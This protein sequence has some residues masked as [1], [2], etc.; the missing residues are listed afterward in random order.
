M[1]NPIYIIAIALGAGFIL[2]LLDRLDRK[3]S[4]VIF[5]GALFAIAAIPSMWLIR[6][7]NGG[8]GIV[9]HTA[10]FEPPFSIH[11]RLF[12]R[13]VWALTLVNIGALLGAFYMFK[14]L[15]ADTARSMV[16]YLALILGINGIVMTR[17]LFNLFVFLEITS[18]AT[19]GLIAIERNIRSLSAGFKYILAGGLAS[20]LYL[21]GT[22]YI[23]RLTGTLSI[24]HIIGSGG[25]V[26]FQSGFVA[27]FLVLSAILIELKP[28]PANGWGIDVYQ[29]AQ[30]GVAAII[31]FGTSTAM[32]FALHKLLPLAQ[33]SVYVVIILAGLIS[34]FLSNLI[35]MKQVDV[36]R[37]LGYSS[38]A[39]IG[40]IFAAMAMMSYLGENGPIYLYIVGGL[41]LNH[42]LAKGG[43]FWIVGIIGKRNMQDWKSAE[44]KPLYKFMM[45]AFVFALVGLPP[46]PGFWAKWYLITKLAT[47]NYYVWIAL[48]L[49]GSLFEAVYLFRWL[50]IAKTDE[51]EDATPW[52][53]AGRVIPIWIFFG[54]IT[55]AGLIFPIKLDWIS[56][57]MVYPLIAGGAIYVLRDYSQKLRAFLLLL[58]VA[59]FTLYVW[60]ELSGLTMVFGGMFL[61]A[62]GLIAISAFVEKRRSG[63]F[64]AL[65][66]TLIL[67]FG[68]LLIAETLLEFLFAWEIMTLASYILITMGKRSRMASLR[69]IIFSLAGSFLLLF[70]FAVAARG[71]PF[72]PISNL[73]YSSRDIG[74]AFVAIFIGFLIKIGAVGLHIWL[75]G[76][77][78]ESPDE[79]STLLSA[80]MSK[81]GIFALMVF[82]ALTGG[83]VAG[84]DIYYIIGWIGLLTAFFGTLLAVFQEDVKYLLAYSSLGQVGYIVLAFALMNHAGWTTALYLSVNHLLF[85]GMLFL[86][87]AGVIYRLKTSKMYEMGG[88]IQ[89]MPLSFISVLIGII[90][91]SGVPPLTGFGGKWLLYSSLI[92]KGWYVQAGIAFFASTIAF[93]YCFRLIHTVFLGQLK[94]ENRDVKEAPI[95][96]LIPQF[97]FIMAIMA[98]SMFPQ[99][100]VKPVAAA[101]SDYF[102]PAL[103]WE[104]GAL[105]NSIGYWNGA[106]V[107]NVTM[108]VF[109]IPLIWL[110]VTKRKSKRVGQFNIVFAAERPDR[111]ETTHF[112]H[113]FFAPYR[114]A[115]G[116]FV[117]PGIE[118]FWNGISEGTHSVASAIRIIYTGNGQTYALY[119]IL[120][121][122][123]LFAFAGGFR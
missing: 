91:L 115:L 81:V 6:M 48:I 69:Y 100:L 40:L 71:Y 59:A 26:A 86:A 83:Y 23:Y 56:Q 76:A 38:V 47:G 29:G 52:E 77:Y 84:L 7:I 36:R 55:A 62:G 17:D 94:T 103:Y 114:K 101:A 99:L 44:I 80:V 75:P 27:V 96:F 49:F 50:G 30:T 43:L 82:A 66:A 110:F 97:V 22:I 63:G 113:N 111:P 37:M 79:V 92:E 14:E 51:R 109:A 34:F 107:M 35:G 9:I 74:F 93:L 3:I 64:Y 85:K 33:Q 87:A 18:I 89:K 24:D 98:F 11:L 108:V 73:F 105:W 20:A 120:Y 104:N 106:L 54:A 10:G 68:T 60:P 41:L 90:A 121:V 122:I 13:E 4:F 25:L 78:S 116:F 117:R 88:L 1:V 46:F 5:F 28:F 67:S 31:A 19:Y 72:E 15:K 21:I 65:L 58:A 57:Y 95:W 53:M 42:F 119:I 16:L 102:A 32:L 118:K 61:I 112:A 2:P 12:Y 8:T 123:A 70:G 39:Q 45:G